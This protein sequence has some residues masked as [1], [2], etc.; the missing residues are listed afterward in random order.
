MSVS[1]RRAIVGPLLAL[2]TSTALICATPVSAS[3]AVTATVRVST[4][5]SVRTGPSTSATRI[6]KLRNRASVPIACSVQ[7][8]YVRGSVRSTTQWDRLSAGT[9]ISHAYVK[10]AAPIS[11]CPADPAPKTPV[12]E[13]TGSMTPAQFILA[14]AG[15]AQQSQREFKVPA[16]VTIA[17]AIL[18]SGWGRSGLATNDH[19]Y[20]GM[21]CSNVGT[22]ATSCHTYRTSECK[23]NGTCYPTEASFRVYRSATD[24][25][26][27][28]GKLLSGAQRYKAAFKYSND[29]NRFIVEV[30]KGGYATS[31]T[32][33]ADITRLM[34]TYNLYKY[35]LS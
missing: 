1:L 23:P 19:N 12:A 27:D 18:E 14:A 17:Q 31:P 2:S 21:K 15:S 20:F 35:N 9:Y 13:P 24:S 29:A 11:S 16:S 4:T 3:A 7:G 10:A 33:A 32:Y 28:H 26:R 22:I 34:T 25:F 8:Q 30:H 6:G 5:L